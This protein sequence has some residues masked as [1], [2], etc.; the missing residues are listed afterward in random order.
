MKIAIV[1]GSH[2]LNSQSF[3]VASY[4]KTELENKFADIQATVINLATM[5]LPFWDESFWDNNPK[6]QKTWKPIQDILVEADS[7]VVVSPEWN[8][9]VPAK[10][11][12]FF[13]FTKP[14]ELGHKPALIVGISA[15]R[16]GTYPISEL[17]SY[18]YMC[19]IPNHVI[20]RDVENVPNDQDLDSSN[21]GDFYIKNKLTNSLE[22]LQVYSKAFVQIRESKVLDYE[23]YP[24]GM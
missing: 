20:V 5:E 18:N 4:I 10:L 22:I 8:G 13:H 23:H 16:G 12:N 1:S 2:R 11:V 7:L 6:W 3:K 17:R 14:T 21:K 15:S 24:F 19:Y 9:S